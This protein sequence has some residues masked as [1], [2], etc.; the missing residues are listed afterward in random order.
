MV[1]PLDYER[2]AITGGDGA[3]RIVCH[4]WP[5]CGCGDDCTQQS[6]EDSPFARRI[7]LALMIAVALIGAGLV[8][9]GMR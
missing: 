3:V 2:I 6:P 4:N 1:H 8:Y 7:L 9:A 5:T